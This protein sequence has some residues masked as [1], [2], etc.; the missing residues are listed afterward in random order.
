MQ[1]VQTAGLPP[2]QGKM[3]FAISGWTRNSRKA[4][5]KIVAANSGITEARLL[6]L[7]Y[8]LE[9]KTNVRTLRRDLMDFDCQNVYAIDEKIWSDH[10]VIE[11]LLQVSGHP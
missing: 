11:R 3:N 2:N 9:I 1:V 7:P 5:V 8:Q 10:G 6:R 4:P